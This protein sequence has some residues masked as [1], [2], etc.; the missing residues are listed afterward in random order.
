MNA[1]FPLPA[2]QL[3]GQLVDILGAD[4]VLTSH[5][6]RRFYSSD[7]YS[8][9][10][11]A[12][13]VIR[14]RDSQTLAR[15]VSAATSA[16]FA[17]APRGG[18]MSYTNGY[19]PIHENTVM[20]DMG[21]MNKII[22]IN[23]SDM[24]VTAEAGV[25][26]AQLYEAIKPTGLRLPF[27]GTF[28][29]VRATVGG[30]MANG[31]LFMG[32]ARYGTAGDNVLGLEVVTANGEIIETGQAGFQ[33]GKP[34]YRT[35]GPDL[36]GLFVHDCGTLGIKTRATMRLITAPEAHECLSFVFK[37]VH[38]TA[39]ALSAIARSGAAE[40]AYVFDPE[41]TA[42]NLASSNTVQDLKT[43]KAVVQGQSSLAKGL[44]AGAKL[45]AAGRNFIEDDLFSLHIVCAGRNEAG[46]AGDAEA[47]RSIAESLEG[48]EIVNSIPLAVR[49]NPFQPL[50]GVIG[51]KGD[52]W[53]ALNSKIAHSDAGALIDGFS[54]IMDEY[55]EAMK[56]TGVFVSR[57][58]IA[59][60]THAFSFEPVF[61]W[62]DEWLPLHRTIPEPSYLK[63]MKEPEANAAATELVAEMRQ[64][65]IK[66]FQDFGAASNQIGRTYPYLSSLKPTTAQLALALKKTLDPKGLMNPGVLGFD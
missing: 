63:G 5:E 48:E 23:E 17:I 10:P 6:E 60:D 32:T 15:A 61:H 20:V 25:T 34:F 57:L 37:G 28:S 51:P 9:A 14:P 66:L 53:A 31:A 35:Y 19:V 58:M 7:V 13:A 42:K 39:Q 30:G 43:V 11:L 2:D 47:C 65:T 46:V 12:A 49:A 26:W 55:D 1:Q 24:Y 29:G 36:T 54:A 62:F 41:S 38:Q 40:E 18:G 16:G 21:S 64:K 8:L 33:N 44:K 45:I 56:N 52:R 4:D 3:V 27:F 22:E 50:N 59:I